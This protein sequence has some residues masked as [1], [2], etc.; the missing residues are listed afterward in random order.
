MTDINTNYQICSKCIMDNNDDPFIQFDSSGICNHC[1]TYDNILKKRLVFL[2]NGLKERDKLIQKI[3]KEGQ[4]NKYDCV[5]G[6]SGGVDS[7]YVA[8]LVKE[9]GLRPLAIHLDNGWNSELS[10]INIQN[11]LEKLKIDLYTHVINWKEFKDLQLSYLKASVI[12][13]EA[14][15][16][17]AIIAVFYKVAKKYNIKNM[18]HGGNIETEGCLP[19]SWV[20]YKGDLMNIK[21]IHKRFGK[22]PITTFT[23]LHPL[24]SLYLNKV[25][26]IK[27]IDILNYSPYN[28]K[29]IK[30]RIIDELNWRDYG[31]KHYES[32]FTR[33]YQSYILPVKFNVDKR[34]S[35][36]STLICSGQISRQEALIEIKK[37]ICDPH[38]LEDDKKYIIKKFGLNKESFEG[39]MSLPIKKHTYYPSYINIINRLRPFAQFLKRI[40]LRS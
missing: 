34:K 16:D 35:H 37:P 24:E 15:T 13:I 32:I 18:I 26:G 27:N 39:L 22:K 2:N 25:K 14:L 19:S 20:H 28:K 40:G 30:N 23:T 38:Q 5:I 21:A 7:T 33:F 8:L 31:G 12:D 11:T 1:N 10:V 36:L 29:N 6:L 17:H 4:G 9:L 3:K